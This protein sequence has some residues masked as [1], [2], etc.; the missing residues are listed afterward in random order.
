MPS[1][2]LRDAAV[3]VGA[4]VIGA[5]A[6]F[7]AGWFA[8]VPP[9]VVN[10]ETTNKLANSVP[11]AQVPP[12]PVQVP[13]APA[14][15]E[16]QITPE[17]RAVRPVDRTNENGASTQETVVQETVPQETVAVAPAQPANQTTDV[18]ASQTR[19]V[20]TEAPAPAAT[21]D[22]EPPRTTGRAERRKPEPKN[23]TK[24]KSQKAVAAK[25]KQKQPK[26]QEVDADDDEAADS[27][28][29]V[30]ERVPARR[31]YD[32]AAPPRENVRGRVTVE[33]ERE[34]PQEREVEREEPR[35]GFG[36]FDL[37]DR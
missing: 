30:Y 11:A 33:R 24:K 23:E 1:Y 8:A 15:T 2:R 19:T 18:P 14:V 10:V 6:G 21:N 9:K 16:A 27:R 20:R 5:A 22:S 3:L 29:V 17:V 32:R 26:Q 12:A 36:L 28:E 25:L 13:Q 31:E 35:R 37:F 4:V 34:R 7:N